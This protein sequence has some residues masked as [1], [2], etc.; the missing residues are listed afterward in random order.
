M[1]LWVSDIYFSWGAILPQNILP[2][3]ALCC[4]HC[5]WRLQLQRLFCNNWNIGTRKRFQVHNL[6][7]KIEI[8][9]WQTIGLISPEVNVLL[10]GQ[11]DPVFFVGA[12]SHVF[13]NQPVF[14]IISMFSNLVLEYKW[15][16]IS[17]ARLAGFST[18]PTISLQV[19][20]SFFILCQPV[21]VVVVVV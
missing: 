13:G 17:W 20:I 14:S 15:Q 3:A 4:D 18:C 12:F 9:L 6:E 11:F 19:I 16:C 8:C 10:D 5:T 1:L 21:V 7:Q 2:T